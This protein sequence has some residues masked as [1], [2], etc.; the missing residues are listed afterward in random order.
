MS[1]EIQYSAPP[2]D[3]ES[4][5]FWE[6]CR[7]HELVL[8]RCADCGTVRHRPR[9]LCPGCLS[10]EIEWIRASGRGTVYSY[11][12]THQ[13]QASPFRGAVPYVLAYVDLEEGVRMLT[14]VVGCDPGD[15]CVGM[16]VQVE[17]VDV[18]EDRS[19]PRFR[20]A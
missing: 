1:R 14:N 4:R 10:G 19:V 13:N 9:A 16:P 11:T 8:Q 6:G 3:W 2:M 18:D 12:V 7:R 17:F 15:V 20:P 5:P